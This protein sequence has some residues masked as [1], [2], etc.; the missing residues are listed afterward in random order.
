MD[1]ISLAVGAV[2]L[3]VGFLAGRFRRPRRT[4]TPYMCT[5]KHPFSQHDPTTRKCHEKLGMDR[6][7]SCRCRQYV[8]ELPLDLTIINEPLPL[9]SK[10]KP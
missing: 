10:D 2:I 1:P 5:C 3:G 6:A 4:P 8:G 7:E 9:P